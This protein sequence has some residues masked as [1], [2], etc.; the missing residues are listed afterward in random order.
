MILLHDILSLRSLLKIKRIL[1]GNISMEMSF[2]FK[3]QVFV[4]SY[5]WFWNSAPSAYNVH[6]PSCTCWCVLPIQ[7]G[8]PLHSSCCHLCSDFWYRWLHSELLL[9]A[10]QKD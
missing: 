2:D 8:S 10:A 1:D 5:Y 7:S 4:F 9:Y 3:E 6:L